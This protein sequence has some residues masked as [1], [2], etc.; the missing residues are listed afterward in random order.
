MQTQVHLSKKGVNEILTIKRG[1]NKGR[2]SIQPPAGRGGEYIRKG[3]IL[4]DFIFDA[5]T[6]KGVRFFYYDT[7][8]RHNKIDKLQLDS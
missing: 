3:R 5:S 6:H 8:I 7:G 1:M 4:G 2:S